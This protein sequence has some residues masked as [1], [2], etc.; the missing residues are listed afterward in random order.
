MFRLLGD[1]RGFPYG[2]VRDIHGDLQDLGIRGSGTKGSGIK[3]SGT[4]PW[5][6]GG[7]GRLTLKGGGREVIAA[8]ALH[9]L[10]VTT[11][12]TL[13]LVETGGDLWRPGPAPAPP[14]TLAGEHRPHRDPLELAGHARAF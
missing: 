13:S 9:R 12:R 10:G 1:G 14:T 11:S 7:D 3:G 2:Q 4:T 8:E 5:S 6:R